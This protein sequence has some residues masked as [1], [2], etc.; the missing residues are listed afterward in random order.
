[1]QRKLRSL[2]IWRSCQRRMIKEYSERT[3]C[4]RTD[5]S[6]DITSQIFNVNTDSIITQS[7]SDISCSGIQRKQKRLRRAV[8]QRARMLKALKALL[9]SALVSSCCT[10]INMH[11][12]WMLCIDSQHQKSG[13][14]G[15][16]MACTVWQLCVMYSAHTLL[17]VSAKKGRKTLSV[18]ADLTGGQRSEVMQSDLD[19]THNLTQIHNVNTGSWLVIWFALCYPLC[20][21]GALLHRQ[22]RAVARS[23]LL[24]S[25]LFTGCEGNNLWIPTLLQ[26]CDTSQLVY[27]F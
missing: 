22:Q 5:W 17:C 15:F 18:W 20:R 16:Y 7:A 26:I 24:S 10:C 11:Y 27:R 9:I 2:C 13:E 4:E 14:S 23:L 12:G 8:R 25:P 1:M 19:I 3:W 6:K 21:A